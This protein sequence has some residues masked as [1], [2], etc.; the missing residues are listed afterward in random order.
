MANQINKGVSIDTEKILLIY[1][2][3]SDIERIE[4]VLA[5]FPFA[6]VNCRNP[7]R[8]AALTEILVCLNDLLQKARDL[9]TPVTFID[10]IPPEV[11][12]KNGKPIDITDYV[13]MIR[14]AVCHVSSGTHILVHSKVYK[15]K[16]SYN[17]I[18]GNK[19]S[20]V[21]TSDGESLFQ[22][23]YADDFCFNFG[24]LLLYYNRHILR[25]FNEA[26]WKFLPLLSSNPFTQQISND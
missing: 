1:D 16:S 20:A 18:Y 5:Q 12:L 6:P 17:I 7:F 22:P 3:R 21:V 10:G 24:R 23:L 9:N 25:A 13:N 2:I 8:Q 26:K 14:N 4:I 19:G 11:T 15:L